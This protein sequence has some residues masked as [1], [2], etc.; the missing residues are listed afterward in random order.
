MYTFKN[1]LKEA[2]E[3]VAHLK[4]VLESLEY[5]QMRFKK[6][7][8]EAIII[9]DKLRRLEQKQSWKSRK[10]HKNLGSYAFLLYPKSQNRGA[11]LL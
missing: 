4:G 9:R 11:T 10:K 6:E 3:E 2:L 1:T 5:E 7:L 8:E